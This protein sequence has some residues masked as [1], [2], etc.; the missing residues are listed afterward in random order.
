MSAKI[1]RLDDLEI[2]TKSLSLTGEIYTLTKTSTLSKEFSLKDQIRRAAI[3][4]PANI[5]EGFGRSTR[6]DFAQ[7]L[8]IALGSVNEVLT[9][10]KFIESYFKIDSI[11]IQNEYEIIAKRIYT[12]RKKLLS[13]T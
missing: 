7:F 9:Y 4:V 11:K 5:A 2:Y 13:H 12:F 3:S 8:S 10:L 6:K 1:T